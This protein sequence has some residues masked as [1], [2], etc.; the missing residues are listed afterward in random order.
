MAGRAGQQP[1][2]SVHAPAG[3]PSNKT[4]VCDPYNK[5]CYSWQPSPATFRAAANSCASKDGVLAR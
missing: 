2:A 1:T 4:F 3:P 5:Y